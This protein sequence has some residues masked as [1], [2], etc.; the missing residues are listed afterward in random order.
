MLGKKEKSPTLDTSVLY[1]VP[2]KVYAEILF[3]LVCFNHILNAQRK[4]PLKNNFVANCFE[5][6]VIIFPKK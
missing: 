6:C 3:R 1:F 2:L 4:I 5:N